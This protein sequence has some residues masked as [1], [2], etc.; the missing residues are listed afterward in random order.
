V[1]RTP[2]AAQGS[3]TGAAEAGRPGGGGAVVVVPLREPL[4]LGAGRRVRVVGRP[5]VVV[6][7]AAGWR[8]GDLPVLGEDGLDEA[9]AG[10]VDGERGELRER[11]GVSYSGSLAMWLASRRNQPSRPPIVGE[12]YQRRPIHQQPWRSFRWPM[13]QQ[14]NQVPSW[15]STSASVF[16]DRRSG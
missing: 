5:V 1:D 9:A 15:S 2:S 16:G 4:D 7:P 8:R 3:A 13:T 11:G 12:A 6:R 14:S 10:L